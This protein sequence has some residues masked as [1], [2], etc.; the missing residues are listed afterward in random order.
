MPQ[1]PYHKKINIDAV[2]TKYSLTIL[3]YLK[4]E[5]F[6]RTLLFLQKQ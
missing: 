4:R 6:T 2:N 1:Q 3:G 5:A